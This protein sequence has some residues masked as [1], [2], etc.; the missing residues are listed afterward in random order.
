MKLIKAV[1][2]EERFD[3]VK[4]AL[5]EK[6]FYGMTVYEVMGRGEQK[7]VRLPYRS[8]LMAVDLLPKIC[9]ELVVCDNEMEDALSAVESAAKTGKIGDGRVFV[10]PV[11]ISLR[12]RTGERQTS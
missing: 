7:G 11:E 12:V 3:F 4:K 5:E 10:L 6:G 2:R 8:G 1:I 9:V